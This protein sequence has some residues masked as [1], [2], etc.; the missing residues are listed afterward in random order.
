M[1]KRLKI[2]LIGA[3]GMRTP[4]MV[5]AAARRTLIEELILYDA[6]PK[7]TEEILPIAK[8]VVEEQ[9]SK[10]KLT[11]AT[12]EQHALASVDVVFISIRPSTEQGRIADESIP[13]KHGLLGQET[14]G[15]G[16]IFMACRTIPEILR[17]ARLARKL[18][19]KAWILNF[20]N[21]VG[22]TTQALID[23]KIERAVGI[24]DS[25]QSHRYA[26]TAYLG[27][28]LQDVRIKVCGL[29][30]LSFC[31]SIRHRS[32]EV[33]GQLMYD[34]RFLELFYPAYEPNWIREIKMLPN[35]YPYYYIDPDL[36]AEKMKGKPL[37]A[38]Q[39]LALRNELQG[40][41]ARRREGRISESQ[42]LEGYRNLLKQR[43]DTYMS[44]AHPDKKRE[45]PLP[46]S[47]GYA[48]VALDF[49]KGVFIS[50]R[51]IVLSVDNAK[52]L[53]KGLRVD[54]VVEVSCVVSPKSIRRG[55]FC[56]LPE[57]IRRWIVEQKRCE[58]LICRAVKDRKKSTLWEAFLASPAIGKRPQAKAVFDELLDAHS[59]YFEGWR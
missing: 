47:E 8:A 10:L 35:E 13:L 7:R 20:T 3:G 33:L 24:C 53:P 59:K 44:Y 32:A 22:A 27:V 49:I 43:E 28:E 52:S 55:A 58:R 4:L 45:R 18:S 36:A 21:P 54:D 34:D 40:L 11:V 48:G 19:P 12:G 51:G 23:A 26:A 29:N 31:Y 17:Y 38:E 57:T 1:A 9:G 42:L 30:H 16:G 39:V 6:D 25:A 2:A 14:I 46:T 15:A 37:R 41:V 56:P 5:E 50:E